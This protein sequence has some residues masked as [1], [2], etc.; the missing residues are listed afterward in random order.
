MDARVVRIQARSVRSFA[1]SVVSREKRSTAVSCAAT[2]W[3]SASSSSSDGA[4]GD[5]RGAGASASSPRAKYS[6]VARSSLALRAAGGAASPSPRAWRP[7]PRDVLRR[8]G[9]PCA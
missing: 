6:A 8:A 1:S 9:A 5:S 2:D 4:R 3:R 7:P